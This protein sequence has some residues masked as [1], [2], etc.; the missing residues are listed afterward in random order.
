MKK[1]RLGRTDLMVTK[2]AFGALPIQRVDKATAVS[3]LRN[4]YDAGINFF[5]TARAYSDSE[6]K[7]GAALSDVRENI[8]IATKSGAST[9]KELKAHLETSLR[10]LKTDYIDIYQLHNAQTIPDPN[11]SESLYGGLLEAKKEGKIRH[12]SFTAHRHD[13][14]VEGVNSGL[15][16]TL[17]YPLSY[18]SSQRDIDLLNL[19]EEK[20][21]GFIAMKALSGG[22][23]S[24]AKA[25]FAFMQEHPYAVPIYGIQRQEELDEFL[26]YDKNPPAFD[27]SL[28]AIIEKEREEFAGEFC[29]ACGYCMPCPVGIEIPTV[30]RLHLLV[31]R[32]P[33]QRFI[34]DE[35]YD[36]LKVVDDCIHCGQ[37]SSR[38]P[39]QMDVPS[40]VRKQY[41]KYLQFYEEHKHEVK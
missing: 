38:C 7:M 4:A 24:S 20:D 36:G 30:A 37:C 26:M 8:V 2:T 12:I 18:L 28:K 39:Y 29:R 32:S 17:Q 31:T 21:V 1:V 15:F 33:Y 6:E 14:A 10:N 25:V 27:D 5:D 9:K 22:L 3:I 19:C 23:C 41:D 16:D 34:S 11:D 13:I 35:Y 40:V